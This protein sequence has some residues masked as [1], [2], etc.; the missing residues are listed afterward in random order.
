MYDL[1]PF[2]ILIVLVHGR[3]DI[4]MKMKHLTLEDRKQIQSGIESGQS[5]TAIARSVG[6]HPSTV[7]KEIIRHRTLKP[8][9]RFNLAVVCS[10]FKNCPRHRRDCSEHCPDYTE[11][12]CMRRDRHIGACN[13]CDNVKNCK[14]DHYFYNA[15]KAHETYLFHL[16]DSRQGINLTTVEAKRIAETIAPLLRKGQSVYQIL[17]NHPEIELSPKSLY[18]YIESGVFKDFGV[19]NFSLRRQ[20]SMKARK[21]LKKRK[22]PINYEGRKYLDYLEF[23]KE[24]PT[25]PTTEMDTIFNQTEGP[26]I[27]TFSFQNTSLMIGFLHSEKTSVS[28]ASSLDYLQELLGND[29]RKLFSLLLTDRGTEFE[30]YELFESN[31]ETGQ[32]RTH[33]FYCDPQ[34]PSQKPHVENNHNYVRDII[35]NGR[36]LQKITQQDLLLLFS[37]INSVPRRVLNGRT[38]YEVFSFFYGE[39]IL[40]KL[41]IQRI[42][43]D[44]VTL[45]PFLLKIE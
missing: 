24:N 17:V 38:P 31:A 12:S 10:R 35:P 30:K 2:T 42:P 29:Y 41:G 43:P 33:I 26:F 11:Q 22:E 4:L 14:L 39:E 19:D 13:H 40:H 6:K 32:F 7:S 20:V 44:T 21:K 9:N 16:S 1:L 25:V 15:I 34:T 5:K 3:K 45:H 28:M 23:I 36:E 37:H 8:R 27:Q 18:N